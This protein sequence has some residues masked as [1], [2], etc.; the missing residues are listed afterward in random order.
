MEPS[1]AVSA[2]LSLY[3]AGGF[4]LLLLT[5]MCFSGWLVGRFL[6]NLITKLGARID[7]LENRQFTTL[8]KALSDN[9]EALRDLRSETHEQTKCIR[10][11]TDVLRARACLVETGH[12]VAMRPVLPHQ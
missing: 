6:F 8:T 4:A 7:E 10:Q 3:Q 11:Q 5:I 1:T 12:H 9:A 2:G